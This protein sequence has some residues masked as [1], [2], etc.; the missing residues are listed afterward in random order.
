NVPGIFKQTPSI[1]LSDLLTAASQNFSSSFQIRFG[2]FGWVRINDNKGFQGH[3][4]DDIKIY[5]AIDDI[6]L[7]SIDQPKAADCNLTNATVKITIRNASPNS[8]SNIPVRMV[9]DGGSP[10]IETIPGPLAA[11]A[12]M[13]YTF[14][15]NANLTGPGYHTI[16]INVQYG[17]D[18]YR[19]NDTLV[20]NV[21]NAPLIAA[22]PHVET[23]E[24]NDGYWRTEGTN[25]SWEYGTPAAI[26]INKAASGTKAWKTDLN[27]NYRNNEVSYLYSP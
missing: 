25:N 22:F 23:F 7:K 12:N 5:E 21:F 18:N 15:A 6:Q 9:V 26:K 19:D 10:V 17:T 14:T 8:I 27:G 20:L 3:N 13:Q 1:E 4:F 16:S 2:H 24:S 11:N